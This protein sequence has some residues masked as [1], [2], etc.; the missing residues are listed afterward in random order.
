[1]SRALAV[2]SRAGLR[3]ARLR[4][5]RCAVLAAHRDRVAGPNARA[6]HPSRPRTGGCADAL[7]AEF[8]ELPVSRPHGAPRAPGPTHLH[9]RRTGLRHP[10]PR[11]V[12]VRTTLGARLWLRRRERERAAARP[13]APRRLGLA[14]RASGLCGG[15]DLRPAA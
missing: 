10:A 2:R 12:V 11:A 4:S 14:A 15:S 6:A 7:A 8:F 1:E 13:D 9:R 3:D 5:G